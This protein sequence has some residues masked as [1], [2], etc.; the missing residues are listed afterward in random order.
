MKASRMTWLVILVCSLSGCVDL[1]EFNY[2]TCEDDNSCELQERADSAFVAILSGCDSY[3]LSRC[4]AECRSLLEYSDNEI[5]S[6]LISIIRLYYWGRH[7]VFISDHDMRPYG[8]LVRTAYMA[9]TDR[10]VLKTVELGT[11]YVLINICRRA[12]AV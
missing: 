5:S 12:V 11:A 1:S 7:P 9:I 2:S 6:R 3:N 10:Q 4:A 8:G